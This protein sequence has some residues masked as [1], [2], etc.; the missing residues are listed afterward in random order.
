MA[1]R[2]VF[3]LKI[4]YIKHEYGPSAAEYFRSHPFCEDCE[5]KRLACLTIHHVNGKKEEV[6]RTLC[7][8]CHMLTHATRSKS[9]TY[10]DY[11]QLVEKQNKVKNDRFERDKKIIEFLKEGWS[12]REI[13]SKTG[14][15]YVTVFGISKKYNIRSKHINQFKKTGR[16]W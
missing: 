15:G 13:E 7:F 5:E 16:E 14:V 6:F 2:S 10:E 4:A 11:L 12:L 9:E 3:L 8:N 1:Y